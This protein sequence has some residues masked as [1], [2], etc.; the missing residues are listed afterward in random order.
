MART[1]VEIRLAVVV[2]ALVFVLDEEADG[3]SEGDA[4]F[5][6]G[7]EVD[8]VFFVALW[9]A[10]LGEEGLLAFMLELGLGRRRR[11]M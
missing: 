9:V 8:E 10:G 11:G 2:R 6:A 4:V 5:E 3:G 1:G 7:L